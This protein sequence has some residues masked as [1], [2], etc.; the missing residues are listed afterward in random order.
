[1]QVEQEDFQLGKLVCAGAV[2]IVAFKKVMASMQN[3][4]FFLIK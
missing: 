1:V 4:T 2:D 3:N